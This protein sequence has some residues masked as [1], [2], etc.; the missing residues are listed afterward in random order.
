MKSIHRQYLLILLVLIFYSNS[1]AQTS[2]SSAQRFGKH[3]SFSLHI[4][5]GIEAP[6][7]S[8]EEGMRSSGFGHQSPAGCFFFICS[9]ETD[10]PRS[11]SG[12]MW[13]GKLTYHL[14]PNYGLGIM[15]SEYKFGDTRGHNSFVGRF[16]IE[17]ELQS[18]SPQLTLGFYDIISISTGPA[19]HSLTIRD[20]ESDT[21]ETSRKLGMDIDLT[22]RIP[23]KS[24][25][26]VALDVHYILAGKYSIGP[27]TKTSNGTS[28][29]F[30]E[31]KVGYNLLTL[32]YGFGIR[33]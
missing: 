29:R 31:T 25:L 20:S 15:Y 11:N 7:K 2:E 3:L 24:L 22:F 17:H 12:F 23:R 19:L 8:I 32:N 10:Y 14:D 28:V 6:A 9:P 21:F 1:D 33:L 13:M 26:F 5:P 16:G 30:R 4:G 18:I 27:F